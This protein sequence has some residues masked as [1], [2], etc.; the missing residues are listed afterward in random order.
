MLHRTFVILVV[1]ASLPFLASC[2]PIEIPSPYD[3]LVVED[4]APEAVPDTADLANPDPAT[5][6]APENTNDTAPEALP[7][8]VD[9]VGPDTPACSSGQWL[10]EDNQCH[11]CCFD[12]DC[13]KQ[14]MKTCQNY[15]CQGIFDP[16]QGTCTSAAPY[17][18]EVNGVFSCVECIADT[19]CTATG[20][21]DPNSHFCG[22]R[23][24][25]VTNGDCVYSACK[26]GGGKCVIDAGTAIM[27]CQ[28]TCQTVCK[29]QVDC[30]SKDDPNTGWSWKPA[31]N[32]GYCVDARGGCDPQGQGACCGTG[33]GC[34]ALK[35]LFGIDVTTVPFGTV[36]PGVCT[37]ETASDCINGQ[38]CNLTKAICQANPAVCGGS[39]I[40]PI[41]WP[42]GICF[43]LNTLVNPI[44]L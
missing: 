17:C 24:E 28:Q 5:D 6:V 37:C 4:T 25:C 32:S 16:C 14:G 10:C 11:A 29:A 34:E 21:C 40:P 30:P 44:G 27:L 1:L 7:E 42:N 3:Q 15:T 18:V 39:S 22:P 13:Q 23:P 43:D 38:P 36:P 26:C 41:G 20:Y 19:Q 12:T 33:Q 8:T 9:E 31:C 35:T 2:A